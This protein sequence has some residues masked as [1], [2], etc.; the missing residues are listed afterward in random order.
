MK[1]FCIIEDVEYEGYY[2][3][4]AEEDETGEVGFLEESADTFWVWDD[5]EE[6]F[7]GRHFIGR[8]TRRG[9]PKGKGKGKG[10]RG[11]SRVK[12][13]KRRGYAH[14]TEEY[15]NEE[16][17]D[18]EAYWS[19]GRGK[20]KGVRGR[21]PVRPSNPSTED[22]RKKLQ[23]LKAKTE[24]KDCG[25]KGHWRGDKQC[26]MSTHA[27]I[28]ISNLSF[29]VAQGGGAASSS[30]GVCRGVSSF[31]GASERAWDCLGS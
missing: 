27:H 7:V 24:C 2:G 19:K 8:K 20:G 3:Y 21:Y 25:K 18:P 16:A 12:P 4:W 10:R 26:T 30:A 15:P 1:S 9:R 22:R 14:E 29:L 31:A 23:E 6:A 11:Y 28:A 13:F 17:P 5:T